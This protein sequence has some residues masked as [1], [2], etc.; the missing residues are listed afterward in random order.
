[1]TEKPASEEERTPLERDLQAFLATRLSSSLGQS[2]TLIRTE[3]PV[4]F[5][6][7]DI[8]AKDELDR[9]VAIEL[10]LGTASRDAVG[11]LQ[12]YM[13]ALAQESPDS[14]IRGI[15]V[16]ASL[17][18]GAEAVLRIARDIQ[19]FSYVITY[20]FALVQESQSTY[21]DWTTR[22][23]KLGKSTESKLWLP[24]SFKR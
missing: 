22:R 6:R 2:L 13:G 23:E 9:L 14:F 17:D 8:L 5:G 21:Q 7:I 15:L 4:P 3:Y 1:M 20:E 11:Q 12:S 24:P 16:A 19:F 10:K 18:A